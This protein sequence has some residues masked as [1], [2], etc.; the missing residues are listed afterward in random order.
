MHQQR[1]AKQAREGD[2]DLSLNLLNALQ[3]INYCCSYAT[4]SN[5]GRAAS[6]LLASLQLI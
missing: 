6:V 3:H 1:H 2:V 5:S 4:A